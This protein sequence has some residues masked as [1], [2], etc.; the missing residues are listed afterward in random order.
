MFDLSNVVEN[1]NG[2]KRLYI[3]PG[4]MNVTIL[5]WS[6]AVNPN[7][8]DLLEV[9]LISN[10]ALAE[11]TE[12][13]TRKFQFYMTEKAKERSLVSVK[14]IVT[15]VAKASDMKPAADLNGFANML[16]SITKGKTLRM[17]FN[18]EEYEYNGEIKTAPRIGLPTFAEATQ[19]GAE[20]EPVA[21]A[22]TKLSYDVN[23]EYDLKKFVKDATSFET[24]P[25]SNVSW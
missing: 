13:A 8:K 9:I 2:G 25:A 10:D 20:Y 6:A 16:N 3:Y 24:M 7:G 19:L 14:H 11:G 22:D 18:G 5:G 4:V 17:K 1:G 21:D 23:N 15:K 12:N